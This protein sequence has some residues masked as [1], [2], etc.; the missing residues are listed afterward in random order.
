MAVTAKTEYIA[1]DGRK[2]MDEKEAIEYD[3]LRRGVKQGVALAYGWLKDAD[4]G[5]Q[6]YIDTLAEQL[7][8]HFREKGQI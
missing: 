8:K 6:G 4:V 5:G 1:E 3:A 2:F 7:F